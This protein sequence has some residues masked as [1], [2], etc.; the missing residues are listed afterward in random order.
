MSNTKSNKNNKCCV[1]S[2][3]VYLK[4]VLHVL[5]KNLCSRPSTKSIVI[6][7]R[8]LLLKVSKKFANLAN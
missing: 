1:D 7:G 8:I 5:Y 4:P 3:K 2:A 6:S